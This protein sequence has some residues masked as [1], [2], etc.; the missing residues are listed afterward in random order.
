[1]NI[2]IGPKYPVSERLSYGL[3]L[4]YN[5][6]IWAF[7]S[8][9][10]TDSQWCIA[11][12]PKVSY[13]FDWNAG[14][15]FLLSLGELRYRSNLDQ[16]VYLSPDGAQHTFFPTYPWGQPEPNNYLWYTQDGT[17]LRL[18]WFP[19]SSPRLALVEFPDGT[20]HT[21]AEYQSGRYRL[22]RMTDA[23]QSGS[24][25]PNYVT[26][27]Y[28]SSP[29]SI[30]LKDRFGR[31]QTIYLAIDTTA[32]PST[33][34]NTV[35]LSAF[36]G[37]TLRYQFSYEVR[38]IIRSCKANCDAYGLQTRTV[39]ARFLKSVVAYNSSNQE[40]ERW[41]FPEYH[42][43]TDSCSVNYGGQTRY[44]KDAPGVLRRYI[45]PTKGQVS[46]EWDEKA[47]YDRTEWPRCGPAQNP[48]NC[49]PHMAYQTAASVSKKQILDPFM[50]GRNGSFTY[51]FYSHDTW[52]NKNGTIY[53]F[54]DE[55]VTVVQ[56][57][58]GNETVHFFAPG[59]NE[60]G[61]EEQWYG[62]LGFTRLQTD[63]TGRYLARKAFRGTA[64]VSCTTGFGGF[65]DAQASNGSQLLRAEY[66]L[67]ETS[68]P[69]GGPDHGNRRL[70]RSRRYFLDDPT[71]CTPPQGSS[72]GTCRFA[73]V[74]KDDYDGYGNYRQEQT[75]GNF[76]TNNLRTTYRLYNPSGTAPWL[77]SKWILNTYTITRTIEGLET[78][79]EHTCFDPGNGLL[80]RR[81]TL[82]SLSGAPQSNDV[83]SV[84]SYDS[85]GNLIAEDRYGGDTQA[86]IS[87][88]PSTSLCALPLPATPVSKQTHQY[89]YG[90]RSRSAWVDPASN[91]ELLVT[92]RVQPDTSTGLPATSWD[93]S[94]MPTNFEYDALGRLTWVKPQAGPGPGGTPPGGGWTQVEYTPATATTMA[95][96]QVS[97]CPP[98]TANCAGMSSP[99]AR[100]SYFY[101]GFGRL[102]YHYRLIPQETSNLAWRQIDY[103]ALGWKTFE[104]EWH[105]GEEAIT[106][107]TRWT[108]FDPFGRPLVVQA[109]DGKQTTFTYT[110]IRRV[111]R[112]VSVATSVGSE[113]PVTTY[114]EYDRHG[115]L[116]SLDEPSGANGARVVTTYAYNVLGKVRQAQTT[117]GSVSQLRQ[118]SYDGRGFLTQERL[119]EKGSTG[120][121]SV[122]YQAFDVFGNATRIIDGPND[123]SF[124]FD[125]AGRLTTVKETTSGRVLKQLTYATANV[126]SD[127]RKGKLIQAVANNYYDPANPSANFQVVESFAYAGTG[128]KVSQKTTTVGIVGGYVGSF[129]QGFG[130]N[131]L[132]ELAGQ[133]YPVGM[134]LPA[135]TISYEYDRGFLKVVK[136]GS[137]VHATFYYHPNGMVAKRLRGNGTKDVILPDP[138]RMARPANIQ[139]HSAANTVLWEAG[140]YL[141]DGVGNVKRMG[142]DTFVYDQVSRLVQATV[143]GRSFQATYNPFGF[144][145]GMAKDGGWQTFAADAAG[146]TNRISG[147]SYDAAGQVLAWGGRSFSWYPTGSLRQ[148]AMS[149][150]SATY[151]YDAKDERVAWTDSTEPGIHYTLRGLGGEILREVHELNGVWSWR[152]DYIFAGGSHIAT[153]DS[154]GTKHVHKDHLGSTRLITSASGSILS[155]HRYWPFGEEMTVTSSPERMRFAGHER[156]LTSYLDYMHARYYA[157]FG[158]RF[159]SVD[160]GRDFDAS[161]P[162]SWNLYAYVRNNPIN[163]FDSTGKANDWAFGPFGPYTDGF[164]KMMS[165]VVANN[166][167]PETP[168][169]RALEMALTA[170][171]VAP[172]ALPAAVAVAGGEL[173]GLGVGAGI[174][175][176]ANLPTFL[177]RSTP[178]DVKV[179][180]ALVGG[181]T[182]ALGSGLGAATLPAA[183]TAAAVGT[184]LLG[185]VLLGSSLA[186]AAGATGVSG[187]GGFTGGLVARQY[188]YELVKSKTALTTI[189]SSVQGLFDLLKAELDR[190]R[191]EAQ[192]VLV[193]VNSTTNLV[194]QQDTQR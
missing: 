72:P 131:D 158:G 9:P 29:Y 82:A 156:D 5:S 3:N 165:E 66:V 26:V 25:Y 151:G 172:F 83:V 164:G 141:Y 88:D 174:G 96:V 40:L 38:E 76:P 75:E 69:S 150:Y 37:T 189:A 70:K 127:M 28:Y 24:T 152:K 139:V 97:T 90:V 44:V 87:T 30:V 155:Q 12:E 64:V 191:N 50:A 185:R 13:D 133:S 46:L 79:E 167:K 94:D 188:S 176:A 6:T 81:R 180:T 95:K 138:N 85:S 106:S 33:Y 65:C 20:R 8:W 108:Q 21:F 27:S 15:G 128:G 101:D 10:A 110:G 100:Q 31:T 17:Y 162:Q 183:T 168:E 177:D 47:Y 41:E 99:L 137:Q 34:V 7:D 160:P 77:L 73:G 190:R 111:A 140:S 116:V 68:T 104:S 51:R 59:V 192:K 175:L 35:V 184:S 145:T 89:L 62:G 136:E 161:H 36:G 91:S 119:P 52:H 67:Y 43:L 45:L 113:A 14:V 169:Q 109:A 11:A 74:L 186:D 107:G 173:F 187:M 149:G 71:G 55:L 157:P 57:P 115:R 93:S 18:T 114:E 178:A 129:S 22:I 182:G 122:T 39:R 148:L 121:G 194:S 23:T 146:R 56:D 117:S 32:V 154:A 134:G 123:L 130:W 16:W 181:T 42:W 112:T 78:Q 124:T 63:G 86:Q 54:A 1:M 48:A 61:L 98:N 49:L 144:M 142:N 4:V 102:T 135:R 84:F 19:G 103:N 159:L 126:G 132:W 163:A 143:G 92:L 171:V 58:L 53:D 2:P 80:L 153:V 193:N 125:R 166:P 147:V 60:Q 105:R 118:W 179:A 120:N 170:T